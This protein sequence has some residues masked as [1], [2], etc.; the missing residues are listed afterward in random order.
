MTHSRTADAPVRCRRLWTRRGVVD[1]ATVVHTGGVVREVR[2][3]RAGD[4]PA[5]DGLVVPGLINAHTHLELSDLAGHVAPGGGYYA[6]FARLRGAARGEAA[7]DSAAR[8]LV[9]LGAAACVDVTNRGDTLPALAVAGLHGVVQHEL[10]GFDAAALP[11]RLAVAARPARAADL[12]LRVSPHALLSTPGALVQACV[13]APP[14]GVPATIHFAETPDEQ[15][16][17]RDG[18][19]PA[20][21]ALDALGRDWRWWTPPGV[22]A[23]AHLDALGVLGP[24]LLLVHA[25]FVSPADRRLI[26]DRGSP[27]CFCPRSNLHVSGVLPDA[28]AWW[29]AGATL[30]LGTDSLASSPDLDVLAEIAPL[31]AAHPAVPADVWLAAVT[32]TAADALGLAVVGAVEPGRAPGLLQLD[33]GRPDDLRLGPPARRWLLPPAPPTLAPPPPTGDSATGGPA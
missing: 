12:T 1:D 10:L 2:P 30:L 25:V 15:R 20:A 26:V 6:W 23:A 9:D 31:L 16:W 28:T 11:G 3:G 17:L 8:H 21:D 5:V 27:V 29:R 7:V 24:G 4:G 14:R 33:L 32:H 13:N 18:D 19:G 22:D